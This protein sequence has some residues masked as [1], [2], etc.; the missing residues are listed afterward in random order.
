MAASNSG[1]GRPRSKT[2][3]RASGAVIW[4]GSA[5]NRP[6]TVEGARPRVSRRSN[7]PRAASASRGVPSW[8]VTPD[9]RRKVQTLLSAFAAHSSAN[10]G[11][12]SSVVPARSRINPSNGPCSATP[13][14]AS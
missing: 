3:V 13:D 9:R 12:Y 11:T 10:T 6:S 2:N 4:A 5:M 1:C 14:P 7:E 8:K